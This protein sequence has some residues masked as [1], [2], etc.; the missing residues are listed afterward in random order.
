MYKPRARNILN[1]FVIFTIAAIIFF[2][3]YNSVFTPTIYVPLVKN[4]KEHVLDFQAS[5]TMEAVE[6]TVHE[7]KNDEFGFSFLYPSTYGSISTQ[8]EIAT[9]YSEVEDGLS[10]AKETPDNSSILFFTSSG[11]DGKSLSVIVD[12]PDFQPA[13]PEEIAAFLCQKITCED[14]VN[15]Q[16]VHYEYLDNVKGS[17][18]L[19]DTSTGEYSV[20]FFSLK[21]KKELRIFV[22]RPDSSA[23][24]STLEQ[25]SQYVKLA[26]SVNI[27]SN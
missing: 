5:G 4:T 2:V 18:M 16:G 6:P 14:K 7:Y 20:W 22:P 26:D 17:Q 15:K 24:S 19:T 25:Y 3:A 12:G 11:P 21:N 10:E 13:V 9:V 23:A 1:S 27:F 8:K